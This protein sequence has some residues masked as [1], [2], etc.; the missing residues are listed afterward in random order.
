MKRDD[1]VLIIGVAVIAGIISLIVSSTLINTPAKRHTQV[2]T[3]QVISPSFPDVKHDPAY[4]A[5]LN[6]SALDPTQPIHIGSDQNT[7]PFR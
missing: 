7:A 2:P 5:F 4:Q 1:Y 3:V 6:N